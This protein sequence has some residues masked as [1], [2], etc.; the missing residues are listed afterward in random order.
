MKRPIF[1]ISEHAQLSI[2]LL[3]DVT[4]NESECSS[5]I[6]GLHHSLTGSFSE[7][8]KDSL[9]ESLYQLGQYAEII[10]WNESECTINYHPIT[11]DHY[12][13]SF[14]HYYDLWVSTG[15]DNVVIQGAT[16]R[17]SSFLLLRDLYNGAIGI[18][19]Y[20]EPK[21]HRMKTKEYAKAEDFSKLRHAISVGSL[22][23]IPH[24]QI[25]PKIEVSEKTV[26]SFTD[27]YGNEIT[28]AGTDRVKMLEQIEKLK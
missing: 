3:I 20:L 18:L 12:L 21:G 8:L 17:V 11:S 22:S 9:A 15:R 24:Y 1:K 26:M 2:P 19:P 25:A 5:L 27:K 10:P 6:Y 28:I 13:K 4:E 14:K 23:A 16:V 7:R